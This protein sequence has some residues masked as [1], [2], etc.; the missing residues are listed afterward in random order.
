MYSLKRDVTNLTN[1]VKCLEI[2]L[3]QKNNKYNKLASQFNGG[4]HDERL[5]DRE[6]R[7][8]ELEDKCERL[9]RQLHKARQE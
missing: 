2:E 7:I 5:E 4:V 1:Q 9:E 6:N 3:E 8:A